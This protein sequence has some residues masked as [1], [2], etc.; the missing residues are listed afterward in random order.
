[1]RLQ[2]WSRRCAPTATSSPAT[3][4]RSKARA[5]NT[6]RPEEKEQIPAAELEKGIQKEK[7]TIASLQQDID[8]LQSTIHYVQNN[9]NIYTNG[10]EYNAH[11]KAK[12]E[13]VAEMKKD[14]EQHKAKLSELQ[15]NARQAGLGSA[16]YQ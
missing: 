13:E 5:T 6:P 1:M 4:R 12:E 9:R 2:R 7:K 10:P 11:Q 8:E 14:L 15:E 16:A 3:D